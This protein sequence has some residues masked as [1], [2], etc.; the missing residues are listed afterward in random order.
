MAKVFL[1][2]VE[3]SKARIPYPHLKV[4]Q[5]IFA[6]LIH[7]GFIFL[8]FLTIIAILLSLDV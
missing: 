1:A 6:A 4:F 7:M 2:A 8:P 5:P 3:D